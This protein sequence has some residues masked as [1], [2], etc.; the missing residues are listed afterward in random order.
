MQC[1][2]CK[3]YEKEVRY[4]LLKDD[5]CI[6]DTCVLLFSEKLS[7]QLKEDEIKMINDLDHH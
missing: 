5:I 1:V 6:C 7:I 3:A 2:F 4:M